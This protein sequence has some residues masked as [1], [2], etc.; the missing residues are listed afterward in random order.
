[1]ARSNDN[2]NPAYSDA[3]L[4]LACEGGH[5]AGCANQLDSHLA[6]ERALLKGLEEVV[7]GSFEF[8]IGFGG[9]AEDPDMWDAAAL[10]Y[11]MSQASPAA[12]RAL[13]ALVARELGIK[14]S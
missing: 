11:L 3:D 1:M 12:R 8:T 5:E 9:A 6:P 7:T 10:G 13:V 14:V 4:L 2:V